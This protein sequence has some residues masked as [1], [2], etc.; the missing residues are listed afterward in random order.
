MHCLSVKSTERTETEAGLGAFHSVVDEMR[1]SML[2]NSRYCPEMGA[3]SWVCRSWTAIFCHTRGM[4]FLG[5]FVVGVFHHA[6]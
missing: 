6:I 3:A 4:N 5:S 2:V 1:D